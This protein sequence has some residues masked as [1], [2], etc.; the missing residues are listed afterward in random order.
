MFNLG[1][2][3]L[4]STA[5]IAIQRGCDASIL[6]TAAFDAISFRFNRKTVIGLHGQHSGLGFKGKLTVL[7]EQ[8]VDDCEDEWVGD[9]VMTKQPPSRE[10]PTDEAGWRSHEVRWVDTAEL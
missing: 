1:K 3:E 8:V 7:R 10:A 5:I 9:Q 2:D 6:K 4:E